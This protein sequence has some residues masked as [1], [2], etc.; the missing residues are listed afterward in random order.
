MI[1]WFRT[2][3]HSLEESLKQS[4]N[5]DLGHTGYTEIAWADLRSGW[6][7]QIGTVPYDWQR[8][9]ETLYR[10][11]K[12]FLSGLQQAVCEESLTRPGVWTLRGILQRQDF[13]HVF[14]ARREE[15]LG[16]KPDWNGVSSIRAIVYYW[17]WCLFAEF[18]RRWDGQAVPALVHFEPI[19]DDV[20]GLIISGKMRHIQGLLFIIDCHESFWDLNC[21]LTLRAAILQADESLWLKSD[22]RDAFS[23]M[24]AREV[25]SLLHA[26]PQTTSLRPHFRQRLLQRA[27]LLRSQR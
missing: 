24:A 13:A 15:I 5:Q 27:Q 26:N 1:R 19:R 25:Q 11:G 3:P 2:K 14:S 12:A 23:E 9:S 10:R 18:R 22:D 17:S 7:L 20:T 16:E 8:D 6:T 4:L 21:Q